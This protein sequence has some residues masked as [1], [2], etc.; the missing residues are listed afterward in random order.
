PTCWG[1]RR[2]DSQRPGVATSIVMDFER[3]EIDVHSAVRWSAVGN[4]GCQAVQFVT[5]VF[6][7]RLLAPEYFGLLAMAQVFVGFANTFSTM[8]FH[9]AIVRWKHITEEML[10]SLFYVTL[11]V[12][13][14]IA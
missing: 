11:A 13:A 2:E 6:L 12:G 14:L 5:S 10:S 3:K 1:L 9:S 8:G 7:A 4:Y